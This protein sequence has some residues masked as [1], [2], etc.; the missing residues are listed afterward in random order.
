MIADLV[1]TVITSL[2]ITEFTISLHKTHNIELE[3]KGHATMQLEE[4]SPAFRRLDYVPVCFKTNT[5]TGEIG[6][7]RSLI[8]NCDTEL[9]CK[10]LL[11]LK[12]TLMLGYVTRRLLLKKLS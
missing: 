2:E 9:N 11:E 10:A 5:L 7:E 6:C 8:L 12:P 4:P 1:T 3:S